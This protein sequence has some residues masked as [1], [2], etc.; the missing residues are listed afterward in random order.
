MSSVEGDA[1]C[2]LERKVVPFVPLAASRKHGAGDPLAYT[3][4]VKWASDDVKLV[5][6]CQA[7][8]SKTSSD[9]EVCT[10]REMVHDLEDAGFVDFNIHGHSFQRPLPG[11]DAG[12]AGWASTVERTGSPAS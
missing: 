5:L 8:N 1:G 4:S 12:D 9:S 2:K 7:E 3:I 11:D 6:E 10:L